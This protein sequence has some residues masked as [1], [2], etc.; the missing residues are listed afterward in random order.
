MIF[1]ALMEDISTLAN[2]LEFTGNGDMEF[3][4]ISTVVIE[5]EKAIIP[6]AFFIVGKF[7]DGRRSMITVL[8]K[9]LTN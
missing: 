1:T 6:G 5:N 3:F 8:N 2:D 9:D 7:E 4:D